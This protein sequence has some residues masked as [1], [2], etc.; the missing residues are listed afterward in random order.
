MTFLIPVLII[1]LIAISTFSYLNHFCSVPDVKRKTVFYLTGVL[2]IGAVVTN[3]LN[4]EIVSHF[5]TAYIL[6]LIIFKINYLHSLAV[7]AIYLFIRTAAVM[8]WAAIYY[9]N[10]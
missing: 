5:V 9:A 1:V 3:L 4:N 2:I 10:T 7:S 6:S 8:L